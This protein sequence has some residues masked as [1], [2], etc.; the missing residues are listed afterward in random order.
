[1]ASSPP[2]NPPSPPRL[3]RLRFAF[4]LRKKGEGNDSNPVE[5]TD[6]HEFHKLLRNEPSGAYAVS[7][8]G[9][10]H[11][12]IHI[13]E[14]GAGQSLDLKGGVRCITDGEIVAWRMDSAYPVSEVPEHDGKPAIRAPYST[15]FV[16]VR[17]QMEFP[18]DT[19]LT[20]FSLYMHLQD[21]AG[22]EA[23]KNPP[24][25]KCW[26]PEFKVT[27]FARDKP[28]PSPGGQP[29]PAQQ[30]GLRVRETH[31]KGA[32]LCILPQDTQ[33]SISE[34]V[35]DWGKVKNTYDAQP[36]PPKVGD[37][38][39][40]ATAIG[41]WAFLGKENGGYV[42]AEVMPDALL[43]RVV[44][45]PM[46]IPVKTGDLMGYLGRH[47]SLSQPTSNRMAHI[48]VF[49]GD[50]IK[51]FLQQGRAWI[52]DHC[53]NPKDW[54]QLGLPSEP[55][56]LRVG[57]GTKLYREPLQ[58]GQ[59]APRT[60][61]TLVQTFAE[62]AKHPENRR[63]ETA[64]GVDN[65]KLNWWKVSGAN[66]LH[67][68]ISGWVREQLF[69]GGRVTREFAQS[70]IDFETYEGKHDPTHTVFAAPQAYVDYGTNADVPDPAALARLSPLM[71]G[72]YRAAYPTGGGCEAATE[73]CSASKNPWRAF[74]LSR[75]I[76][77]HDSEWA[78]PGKWKQ[79]IQEIE[80]KTGEK[81]HHEAEQERIEKLVWWEDVKKEVP[82]LPGPEVFHIHPVA[83]VGNFFQEHLLITLEMLRAVDQMG[84]QTYHEQIL[85]ALNRF[86]KGYEIN[87]PKRIAHF[88]SQ[89]FVESKFINAEEN[90]TYSA[91][92]MKEVFGCRPAPQNPNAPKFTISGNEITC[93]Y[94]Q[95]RSKLWT[96]TSDYA[97]N[98]R[99][100]ANYVYANRY[101][102]G[103]EESGDGHK[104]RGRGLI[105]TT[106]KSNYRIL[107]NEHNKRFPQDQL[108][109]V[110]NPDLVLSDIQYGIESAFVY[111]VIT[112]NLNPI[113]EQGSVL[114]V[115]IK[116]NGGTHGLVERRNAYNRLAPLLGLSPDA[117]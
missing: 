45:P 66:M 85:P 53:F 92:R 34:R 107:T 78:N 20:F 26:S 65:L 97:N 111:W 12:G 104:Y 63:P 59:D 57:K 30:Q 98:P 86:A 40:V 56:I 29:A 109:F 117:A 60:D 93:L 61:V 74:S 113:S 21:F 96:N 81:P 55:T 22:Y 1:M 94:G 9:L 95:L 39:D 16:L 15:S 35:G 110:Q 100:L 68:G 5:I 79:L 76:I 115:T 3:K 42:V 33:F 99:N 31:P 105:Q 27:T 82:D 54:E 87:S 41:G 44:I 13:T 47:D 83:L 14:D 51:S 11:G 71:A 28:K 32:P 43:D 23:D 36:Y 88:L 4:P 50:G 64:P 114:D 7:N 49:C 24:R 70:W 62:L 106:F 58:E 67:Q 116:V 84:N 38:V 8:K 37:Y 52:E 101:E 102:N 73:L 2:T 90:L 103:P 77:K 72:V 18:R 89:V 19:K 112:R 25:P 69:P 75:C 6:E 10:W 17:H 80:K 91:K 48:E 108:D 46:P